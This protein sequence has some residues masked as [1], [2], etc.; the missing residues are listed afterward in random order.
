MGYN[1]TGQSH[2]NGVENE[3]DCKKWI[4]DNANCHNVAFLSQIKEVKKQGGTKNKNDL[5]IVY[6][7]D[8]NLGASVKNRQA[9]GTFDW[10]N[11]STTQILSSDLVNNT[12][13][14]QNQIR[15][16]PLSERQNKKVEFTK[17]R[18]NNAKQLIDSLTHQN[19]NDFLDETFNQI[20]SQIIM[21]NDKKSKKIHFFYG[22]D[23]P[24]FN[25]INNSEYNF[26]AIRGKG[27]DSAKLY[28]RLSSGGP[29]IDLNLRIRHLMNNGDSAAIGLNE[30]NKNKN[31][32]SSLVIKLQQENI[33]NLYT[34]LKSKNQLISF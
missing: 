1:I 18:K 25:Y 12:R 16:L 6:S 32:N 27:V 34:I 8:K 24:I 2:K 15:S 21:I 7:D 11:T 9:A 5:L 17:L 4:E 23:H 10:I 13:S 20:K 14:F 28:A 33:D 26:L 3:S 29:L 19:I 22:S 30:G 31:Q